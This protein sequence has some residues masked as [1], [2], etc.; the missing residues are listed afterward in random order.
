MSQH[1][2]EQ[3]SAFLDGELPP[4]ERAALQAHLAACARCAGEL[5]E[6]ALV[7]QAACELHEPAPEGYFDELPG[8][9]RQRLREARQ[10]EAPAPRP[11]LLPAWSWALAATALLGL[12]LP[13]LWKRQA[14]APLPATMTAPA[15]A[16]ATAPQRHG[17]TEAGKEQ[18]AGVS[19]SSSEARAEVAAPKRQG[20]YEA[21]AKRPVEHQHA[22]QADAGP[23]AAPLSAPVTA[24]P[25]P[26]E[27]ARAEDRA[28]PGFAAAP[29]PAAASA[30]SERDRLAAVGAVDGRLAQSAPATG[31]GRPAASAAEPASPQAEKLAEESLRKDETE[32]SKK[33]LADGRRKAELEG[34][35]GASQP[36]PGKQKGNA[37][38]FTEL[39]ARKPASAEEARALAR[40][41][42]RAAERQTDDTLADEARL[43]ALEALAEA[44]RLSAS[45]ADRAALERAVAAYAA[46]A[47]AA[48]KPRARRL[49]PTAER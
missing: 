15:G 28:A 47:D 6:L 41:W 44:W 12:L 2:R 34:S 16:P 32:P 19:A 27:Q 13:I 23:A 7:A 22:Q 5:E 11:R 35:T 29:P 17:D 48:Q 45:P 25:A 26:R 31:A 9:V 36:A 43:R 39:A 4:A 33:V 30:E 40:E 21:E 37:G 46:R 3:L 38:D 14:E 42:Q 24:P 49:L 20:P 1:P 8:R 10:A 18:P